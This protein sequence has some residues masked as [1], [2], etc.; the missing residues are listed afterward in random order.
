MLEFTEQ[1]QLFCDHE[2]KS[3]RERLRESQTH[4]LAIFELLKLILQLRPLYVLTFKAGFRTNLTSLP[5]LC[6]LFHTEQ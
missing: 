3:M 6:Y 1:Q 4:W 5:V 2:V